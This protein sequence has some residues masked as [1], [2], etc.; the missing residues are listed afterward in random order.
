[1]IASLGQETG[2]LLPSPPTRF[3]PFVRSPVVDDLIRRVDAARMTA[4]R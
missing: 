4:R 3:L 2:D 1:L